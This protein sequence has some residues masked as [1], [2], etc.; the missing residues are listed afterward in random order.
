MKCCNHDC[1]QGRDCPYRVKYDATLDII[2]AITIALAVGLL[3]WIFYR[4]MEVL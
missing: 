2:E 3:A 4:A 1:N